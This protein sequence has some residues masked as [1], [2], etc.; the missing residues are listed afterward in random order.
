MNSTNP[1]SKDSHT[2]LLTPDTGTIN[3]EN[4]GNNKDSN[5]LAENHDFVV[6]CHEILSPLF[7]SSELSKNS[8][9]LTPNDFDSKKLI[10]GS[11]INETKDIQ[12]VNPF[13]S[14]K[15]RYDSTE[16][17][18]EY[19]YNKKYRTFSCV[20]LADELQSQS[21][22]MKSAL[23]FDEFNLFGL[24]SRMEEQ[25]ISL[26]LQDSFKFTGSKLHQFALEDI[27][28]LKI[29][30]RVDSLKSQNKWS[31]SQIKQHKSPPRGM[32]HWDFLLE[33]MKDMDGLIYH[34]SFTELNEERSPEDKVKAR[35]ESLHHASSPRRSIVLDPFSEVPTDNSLNADQINLSPEN[36]YNSDS[37][38]FQLFFNSECL[39]FDLPKESIFDFNSQN[40]DS[41]YSNILESGILVPISK[42]FGILNDHLSKDSEI[43]N[44]NPDMSLLPGI[45]I[46]PHLGRSLEKLFYK[47]PIALDIEYYTDYLP[48]LKYR[49]APVP[50][51]ERYEPALPILDMFTSENRS[52]DKKP[53]KN[54]TADGLKVSGKHINSFIDNS[55]S[56]SSDFQFWSKHDQLIMF[57][58]SIYGEN[59]ELVENSF[60]SCFN[61][62]GDQKIHYRALHSRYSQILENESKVES[63]NSFSAVNK[64]FDFETHI[65]K[66]KSW[67]QILDRWNK[68][69][70]GNFD[71]KSKEILYSERLNIFPFNNLAI[72]NDSDLAT[73]LIS[74]SQIYNT[75]KKS[76]KKRKHILS[77][78]GNESD[79]DLDNSENAP[80]HPSQNETNSNSDPATFTKGSDSIVGSSNFKTQKNP[81]AVG[82]K[83]KNVPEENSEAT[84]DNSQPSNPSKQQNQPN[85]KIT[86][87]GQF[88]VVSGRVFSPLELSNFKAERDRQLQQLVFDQRNSAV[89]NPYQQK[90][91]IHQHLNMPPNLTNPLQ[92][93]GQL[94]QAAASNSNLKPAL[95]NAQIGFP[96]SKESFQ[97]PPDSNI[98]Q[99]NPNALPKTHGQ[100]DSVS[101]SSSNQFTSNTKIL[102][103]V[104]KNTSNK[105]ENIEISANSSGI[106]STQVGP[107]N[108]L[109]SPDTN[110]NTGYHGDASSKGIEPDSLINPASNA[111]LS[112]SANNTRDSF[113]GSYKASLVN[114]GEFAN[115]IRS[116]LIKGPENLQTQPIYANIQQQARQQQNDQTRIADPQQMNKQST[117]LI[118]NLQ[119]VRNISNQNP[120]P[121]APNVPFQHP[122][123][124]DSNLKSSVGIGSQNEIFPKFDI[125]PQNPPINNQ[126]IVFLA[127]QQPGIHSQ[128]RQQLLVQMTQLQKLAQTPISAMNARS[129][130]MLIQ[131]LHQ[132]QMHVQK[133]VLATAAANNNS[134]P[135]GTSLKQ[136]LQN[137]QIQQ[138]KQQLHQYQLQQQR[139]QMQ[140]IQQQKLQQQHQLF[141]QQHSQQPITQLNQNFLPSGLKNPNMN[142]EIGNLGSPS[143]SR[144][145]S[146]G[147]P[148]PNTS[149]NSRLNNVEITNMNVGNMATKSENMQ[150]SNL[151]SSQNININQT[152]QKPNENSQNNGGIFVHPGLNHD[153]MSQNT[154]K[155]TFN[156]HQI[157][158]LMAQQ[159]FANDSI[160]NGSPSPLNFNQTI[161]L[162]RTESGKSKLTPGCSP[163]YLPET[164]IPV[165][166]ENISNKSIDKALNQN[167][168][169]R[170][171]PSTP[172][173]PGNVNNYLPNTDSNAN[174]LTS[175]NS[176]NSANSNS[177][178][179]GGP[180]SNNRPNTNLSLSP[181][182][183]NNYQFQNLKSPGSKPQSPGNFF[184][185][186]NKGGVKIHENDQTNESSTLD[187]N[188]NINS[189]NPV[190]FSAKKVSSVVPNIS[191]TPVH[192]LNSSETFANPSA[193]P[194]RVAVTPATPSASSVNNIQLN[195]FYSSLT[196]LQL[197][198]IS[199]QQKQ[200]QFL[201]QQGAKNQAFQKI[202]AQQN[203]SVPHQNNQLQTLQQQFPQN[204]QQNLTQQQQFLAQLQQQN[205]INQ[206]QQQL[207]Q[208]QQQQQI[209]QQQHLKQAQLQ[210]F[211][212]MLMIQQQKGQQLP[213]HLQ[214]QLQLQL[215]NQNSQQ[216]A[217]QNPHI[218]QNPSTL[219]SSPN[220]TSSM[221]NDLIQKKKMEMMLYQQAQLMMKN[222]INNQQNPPMTSTQPQNQ[223]QNYPQVQQPYQPQQTDLFTKHPDPLK[224]LT[225]Q[226]IASIL[227]LQGVDST[228]K[229][230]GFD[231]VQTP[232]SENAQ[233]TPIANFTG[234][235]LVQDAP[236]AFLNSLSAN[237]ITNP[238]EAYK[239]AQQILSSA[240]TNP[241]LIQAQSQSQL[242]V[243][244]PSAPN[245]GQNSNTDLNTSTNNESGA[246]GTSQSSSFEIEN[247]KKSHHRNVSVIVGNDNNTN[248]NISPKPPI[249]KS[250]N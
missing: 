51:F 153:I 79:I 211:Q 124:N 156:S 67:S 140:Q 89:F 161:N 219:F 69:L 184:S 10:S 95:N 86:K 31:F 18:A 197:S 238:L 38:K 181:N 234:T 138:Q 21:K 227:S 202:S 205:I 245:Q 113:A 125:Q 62:I 220:Q 78:S 37:K 246:G 240:S 213:Q 84:I 13:S 90:N 159:Q 221:Q 177:S 17:E 212:Q 15:S 130:P 128:V 63:L 183:S 109:K 236:N 132:Q 80:S 30:Q 23:R 39:S 207:Q 180:S 226:Q 149:Y 105:T 154:P 12:I 34:N 157:Q 198:Q 150:N 70:S 81:K 188:S 175:F 166:N 171:I 201:N 172:L 244:N 158:Q 228:S 215:Q 116:N 100:N 1:T 185:S 16:N 112:I 87:S 167:P 160:N 36:Y 126:Q 61:L 5:S 155:N 82:N 147:N 56:E 163:F 3:T 76:S 6:N 218:L 75:I 196:P 65:S 123:V 104:D 189:P 144:L 27:I 170:S 118:S 28:N 241:S 26:Y 45:S 74:N 66:I 19:S 235:H 117:S 119:N 83:D 50:M 121:G 223:I 190:N 232:K 52:S 46:D 187:Q 7:V 94:G 165:I 152:G 176:N 54:I 164:G 47:D 204:S 110:K 169:P 142:V 14:T 174:M 114:S 209:R 68:K 249:T 208:Q 141:Q 102:P 49:F 242:M 127:Q 106:S 237:Q 137:Q 91:Q 11:E 194:S 71:S 85:G 108:S 186:P 230:N 145:E 35:E 59:S 134:I 146:E 179:F 103:Q 229:L 247:S 33:E 20:Y 25:P 222:Q 44:L 178:L 88:S 107:S 41:V 203:V 101:L 239:N 214:K 64:V 250:N 231:T 191:I 2:L 217:G 151:G 93:Q 9:I 120:G 192:N 225:N 60:N 136:Q 4:T 139:H 173:V 195:N 72:S 98:D 42:N 77:E 131:S 206:K 135:P 55:W 122:L 99:L 111:D 115:A 162:K 143:K 129:I 29:L 73:S 133:L 210:Q 53:N 32:S 97:N 43:V 216:L 224:T 193:S 57:V 22:L 40:N 48:E 248:S 92:I 24:M 168:I 233:S 200:A 8:D 58:F 96:S 243:P 182:G 148:P 199:A